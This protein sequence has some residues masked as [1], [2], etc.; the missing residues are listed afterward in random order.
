MQE[1]ANYLVQGRKFNLKQNYGELG[2]GEYEFTTFVKRINWR[3]YK[4]KI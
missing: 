4:N 1:D 2:E 3:L